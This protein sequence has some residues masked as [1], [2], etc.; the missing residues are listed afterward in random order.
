M[1]KGWEQDSKELVLT[2]EF[3][4]TGII[5]N[6]AI[7]YYTHPDLDMEVSAIVYEDGTV[8]LPLDWQ[9]GNGM[10]VNGKYYELPKEYASFEKDGHV[11]FND[12]WIKQ[13]SWLSLDGQKTIVVNGL[14]RIFP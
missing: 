10:D 4:E 14:P 2:G 13:I 11:E 6:A 12:D 3:H 5:Q 1:G 7:G 8:L 9:Q